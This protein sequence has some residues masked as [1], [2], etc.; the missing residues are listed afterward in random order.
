[1]RPPSRSLVL[2][3]LAGSVALAT[4]RVVAGDLA[5]LH[6]RASAAGGPPGMVVTAVRDLPLGETVTARDVEVRPV[7]GPAPGSL[8]SAA[9]ATGRVVAVPVLSGTPVLDRHLV[10]RGRSGPAALVPPGMRALRVAAEPEWRLAPGSVVDVL[11]AADPGGLGG[12]QEPARTVAE[13]AVVLD[14]NGHA[15]T[16]LVTVDAARLVAS[17]AAAGPLTL[18]LAPPEEAC[19]RTSSSGSSRD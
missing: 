17:A 7:Q 2:T 13:G 5:S 19:C 15:I 18:A 14:P 10:P 11:A 16:L 9:S 3:L 8:R 4:A 12:G 6:R 1:M